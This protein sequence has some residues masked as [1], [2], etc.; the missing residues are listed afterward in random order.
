MESRYLVN[1]FFLFLLT[2][3]PGSGSWL[4]EVNGMVESSS[5]IGDPS[6]IKPHRNTLAC[7]DDTSSHFH[8]S[9]SLRC[10]RVK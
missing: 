6:E 4:A 7:R 2:Y 10:P 9:P 3:P 5:P 1:L 8:F